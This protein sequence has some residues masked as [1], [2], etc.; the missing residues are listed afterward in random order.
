MIQVTVT[1]QSKGTANIDHHPDE[2]PLC[3]RSMSINPVY[4]V[5]ISDNCLQ[6]LY[7]CAKLECHNLF[8]AT[9]YLNASNGY[10]YF[11]F[12][13]PFNPIAKSVDPKLTEISPE[14]VET[15]Q[16]SWRAKQA[17]MMKIAGTGFRRALEFLVKDYAT[18]DLPDDK[19][20]PI[21]KKPMVQCIREH[22]QEDGIKT[23]AE[24]AAWLGNDE[25]HYLRKW[26]DKDINDLIDLID[27]VGNWIVIHL[28]TEHLKKTMPPP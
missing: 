9:F 19:K 22:I 16:Q 3:H 10:F 26:E 17:N 25:T 23:V 2:C 24:R 12:A 5:Q 18:R 11:K 27:S 20:E 6:G 8:I 14:F 21:R 15:Y 13:A 4:L 7:Q 28:K 1:G